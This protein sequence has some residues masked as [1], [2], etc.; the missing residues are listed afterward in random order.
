MSEDSPI[1]SDAA[2]DR[3]CPNG[4]PVSRRKAANY[5]EEQQKKAAKEA[6]DKENAARALE[7]K[8]NKRKR[9]EVLQTSTSGITNVATSLAKMAELKE[10][11]Q[12]AAK[13]QKIEALKLKLT[14]GLGDESK[15]KQALEELLDEEN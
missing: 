2:M 13:R 6:A 7:E 12:Q 9:L 15:N 4:D 14:L 3:A 8:E 5:R 1:A 11:E 10:E